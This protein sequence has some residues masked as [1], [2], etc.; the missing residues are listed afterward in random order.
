MNEQSLTLS[1]LTR[2]ISS[3]IVTTPGLTDVWVTGETSD[4]R[5]SG[6]HCY[7]EL[8]EKR[9]DG[10]PL[11]KCRAVIWAGT[12]ARI[13]AE[14]A[15]ITG[16]PLRS[17]MKIMARVNV[18]FHAVY[19]LSLVITQIDASYTAGDLEARRQAILARLNAEGVANLNRMLSWP[20]TPMRIAVISAKG[21]AGYG[22]FVKHL[23]DNPQ[24]LRFS[25][26]LFEAA[27]QGERTAPTVIAALDAVMNSDESFDCVVIIR[28]GGAVA[29]LAWFDDY[30]LAAAVA[31][32]P[33][34]V[35]V[36][37][38]HQRD[39]CVL[40]YV[41]NT[42]VKTPT[43]AA[44]VLLGHAG[45]ALNALVDTGRAILTAVRRAV[46]SGKEQL[47]YCR[48]E[49]PANIQRI[50]SR[51]KQFVDSEA[52]R[53]LSTVITIQVGSA[54]TRLHTLGEMLEALSP[55]ATLKRGYSITR[56]D[57][58]VVTPSDIIVPGT[59]LTTEFAGGRIIKSKAAEQ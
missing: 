39:I 5:C 40:D 19:G 44:E 53:Q 48:G 42:S 18:S 45:A 56:V 34:P 11:A 3:A 7:L 26:T 4:V 22:D 28:G 20:A 52:P 36:G 16:S 57:G 30:D 43:A 33:L 21:A 8:I 58:H 17:D 10:T 12:F 31:Q 49:L 29:D 51:H 41:A 2:R 15:R 24:R 9:P 50:L 38:G 27:M 37:I 32:Y 25:T 23:H 59:E 13:G 6:G 55:L 35:I 46:S 14:F 47:A 54:R 1:E